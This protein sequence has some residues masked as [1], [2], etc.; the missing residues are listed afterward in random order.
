MNEDAGAQSVPAGR[1]RLAPARNES[2]QTVDFIVEQDNNALFSVQPAVAANGTLTYTPAADANGSHRHGA[3]P[4]RRRHG[5]R[6]RRHERA[7]DLHDHRQRG[8]RCPELHQGRGS[9]VSEDAAR[10]P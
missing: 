2:G 10:R 4:R 9:D 7:A 5:Q 6:R 3:D 1:R 8:Q